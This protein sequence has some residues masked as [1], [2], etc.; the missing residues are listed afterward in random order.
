MPGGCDVGLS[1]GW[2]RLA[3][4]GPPRRGLSPDRRSP[5]S[6]PLV[7]PPMTRSMKPAGSSRSA[8]SGSRSGCCHTPSRA[9]TPAAWVSRSHSTAA[10]RSLRGRSS[11]PTSVANVCSAGPP[12]ARRRRRVS[13]SAEVPGIRSPSA[14]VTTVCTQPSINASSVS[15]RSRAAVCSGVA[16]GSKMPWFSSCSISDGSV[17]E[18]GLNPRA[19]SSIPLM[20]IFMPL[21]KASTALSSWLASHGTWLNSRWCAA[22]R[23]ARKVRISLRGCSSPSANC[24]TASGISAATP[25]GPSGSPM[26]VEVNTSR[27]NLPSA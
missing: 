25:L 16:F 3:V 24:S 4:V 23:A 7:S 26:S 13:L 8:E 17:S 15:S 14:S 19:K 12:V 22:S 10:S 5:R 21:A 6:I 18:A 11:R 27:L 2:G 1:T 9:S 20:S